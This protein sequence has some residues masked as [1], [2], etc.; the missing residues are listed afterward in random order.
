MDDESDPLDPDAEEV[1]ELAQILGLAPKPDDAPTKADKFF[2]AGA[3]RRSD[4]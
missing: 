4:L 1:D 2:C 3:K